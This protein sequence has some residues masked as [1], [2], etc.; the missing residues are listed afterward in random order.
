ME[1]PRFDEGKTT[2]LLVCE[3]GLEEFEPE[4]F[5]SS[6]VVI[7]EVEKEADL[8]PANLE[9]WRKECGAYRVLIEYN[10][11]WML[12]K[13]YQSLPEGWLVYQ[14]FFV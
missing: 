7:R 8:T 6:K 2:L 3:E 10:G 11:M 13:L 14:E 1:D 9:A 4:K 5:V 12:E